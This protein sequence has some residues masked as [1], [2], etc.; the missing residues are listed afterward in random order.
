MISYSRAFTKDYCHTHHT[1]RVKLHTATQ[2]RI[3]DNSREQLHWSSE[4]NMS[5]KLSS[6]CLCFLGILIL[7]F[8]C[9]DSLLVSFICRFE[10]HQVDCL[11]TKVAMKFSSRKGSK[12]FAPK[13]A[14]SKSSFISE[15]QINFE[16][17]PPSGES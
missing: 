13:M 14:R 11:S 2:G 3:H 9:K 10:S 15:V 16:S 5:T 6:S 7:V 17:Y 8:Y 4:K 12:K 1:P